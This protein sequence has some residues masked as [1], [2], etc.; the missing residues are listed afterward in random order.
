LKPQQETQKM[1]TQI[2]PTAI[3]SS[4]AQIADGVCI[5]PYTIIESDVIIGEGCYIGPHVLIA[6]GARIGKYCKIHKGSVVSTAPQDLT[7]DNEP[8]TF[9]IGDNTTIREFCTL[10]RGTKKQHLKSAVGGNCLLMAYVHV[11]HDCIIGN[12]VIIANSV[13][14]AGHVTIDDYAFIGGL[15]PI[16]QFVN[17]GAHAIVGGGFRVPKDIPPYVMA[18]GWPVTFER[19]NI[20]GL[21]RRGFS[22]E[23]IDTLNEA[24]RILYFSKLNVSQG[25]EKIKATM[26]MTPE[27]QN[28]LDFIAKSKRGIISVRRHSSDVE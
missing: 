14:M 4:K 26:T 23:T 28:I 3:V 13:Q 21:R 8:T 12:N 25:V 10:N 27:L 1:S 2:H 22:K 9:E 17:I 24:Y 15:V 18:G 20:I 16:H 7:Y 11:A 19:L 5:E 6:N